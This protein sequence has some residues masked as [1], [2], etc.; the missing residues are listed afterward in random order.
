MFCL[1]SASYGFFSF[2]FLVHQNSD[3]HRSVSWYEEGLDCELESENSN[4]RPTWKPIRFCLG[5]GQIGRDHLCLCS[6]SILVANC[7]GRV[8]AWPNLRRAYCS[9]FF[10]WY[11]DEKENTALCILY[12][13]RRDKGQEKWGR[14]GVEFQRKPRHWKER[15]LQYRRKC[16]S[17]TALGRKNGQ[18]TL[19]RSKRKLKNEVRKS[20]QAREVAWTERKQ[21]REPDRN[22]EETAP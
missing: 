17:T 22:V 2:C 16:P 5:V 9:I 15:E 1:R 7:S 14:G 10:F 20:L 4:M 19:H 12:Q 21:R 3:R 18:E 13:S 6:S 11:Q 8:F